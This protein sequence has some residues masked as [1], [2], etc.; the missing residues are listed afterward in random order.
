[1]IQFDNVPK[2]NEPAGNCMVSGCNGRLWTVE[3]KTKPF[4]VPVDHC[5]NKVTVYLEAFVGPS[6]V[7][8]ICDNC[9]CR[10]LQAL[11]DWDCKV[12]VGEIP[13][14]SD[15]AIDKDGRSG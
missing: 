6:G 4:R 13:K 1:M 10:S 15:K 5:G 2:S 7:E 14:R 12:I 3:D 11:E 8:V 9:A